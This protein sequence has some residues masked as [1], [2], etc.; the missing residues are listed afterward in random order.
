MPQHSQIPTQIYNRFLQGLFQVIFFPSLNISNQL[1]TQISLR[2]NVLQIVFHKERKERE[3][4]N[5]SY[6][7]H[8]SLA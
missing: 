1:G 8:F 2:Q 7:K 3:V 5:H 6:F 4:K